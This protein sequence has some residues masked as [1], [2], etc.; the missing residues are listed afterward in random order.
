[1]AESCSSRASRRSSGVL[2]TLS[3][4]VLCYSPQRLDAGLC[5]GAVMP[6]F[7]NCYL[8]FTAHPGDFP[9]AITVI[10]SLGQV[11]VADLYSGLT[12]VYQRTNIQLEP[13]V[14]FSPNFP[15][16]YTGLACDSDNDFLYWVLDQGTG[17]TLVRTGL[18]STTPLMSVPLAS[19]LGGII[20]DIVYNPDTD[21]FW[22]VDLE[23][24]FYFE[25]TNNGVATG[26][27]FMSPGVQFAGEAFGTGITASLDIEL[28]TYVLD[29]PFGE[30]MDLATRRVMKVVPPSGTP[31]G[32]QYSLSVAIENNIR[33]ISGIA[34]SES[35]STPA[36]KEFVIDALDN[37][38]YEVSLI[39]P[40]VTGITNLT[41]TVSDT[42]TIDLSWTNTDGYSGIVVRRNGVI[43]TTPALPG[44]ATT[45]EDLGAEEGTQTYT[46]EPSGMMTLQ[47]SVQVVKGAGA[48]VNS[49]EHQG[50]N[51]LAIEVVESN[52]RVYVA[53]LESGFTFRY[54]K[55]LAFVD[56]IPSPFGVATTSGLTWNSTNNRLY[57]YN[58]EAETMLDTDVNGANPG[59]AISVESPAGG[60]IGDID[61]NP[62]TGTF[63]A[64][65]ITEDVYFEFEDDGTPTGASFS[66]V[67]G[68]G[69]GNGLTVVNGALDIPT[70][71]SSSPIVNRVLRFSTLGIATGFEYGL[72][73]TTRS[74]FVN[75]ID[76]TPS[77]SDGNQSEYV[78]GN[79]TDTIYE[80]TL[81]AFGEPFKRGDVN[82]D[83]ALNIIDATFL[84]SAL[85]GGGAV[86]Q[87]QDSMDVNDDGSTN[88]ADV[89]ALLA[90]LFVGGAAPAAPF[91]VCAVDPTTDTLSCDG[92]PPCP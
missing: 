22:G 73:P 21:T 49:V 68:D 25:F 67:L 92:F 47:T 69:R 71:Q 58:A 75:G 63:W 77:G 34:Y 78:V 1:M 84:L 19:P 15:A 11:L 26:N 8:K 12:F 31:Y 70:G 18:T 79:D 14:L 20:G 27:G 62:A 45:Y 30:P 83:A 29:I 32:L 86:P 16:T 48:F 51:A 37:R 39:N 54:T 38:L 76:W 80:L 9:F 23:N 91:T 88:L 60:A 52:Q 24:D 40:A 53:D 82:S 57:W 90:H 64:V 72:S 3:A 56:S 33:W 6:G 7:G 4:L 13:A 17:Q 81:F 36:P 55:A 42:G 28:G 74:G 10:E 89:V 66:F 44:T 35:G 50:D 43:I 59:T 87:C 5:V 41:A 65:D 85:F 61:F 46:V 2:L